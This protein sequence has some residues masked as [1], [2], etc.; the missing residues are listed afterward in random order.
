MW[1]EVREVREKVRIKRCGGKR[2]MG[3]CVSLYGV[4]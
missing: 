3:K 4:R 2:D 1:G